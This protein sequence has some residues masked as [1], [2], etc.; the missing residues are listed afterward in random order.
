MIRDYNDRMFSIDQFFAAEHIEY[1]P[2]AGSHAYFE[3]ELG[4]ISAKAG[5]TRDAVLRLGLTFEDLVRGADFVLR[6]HTLSCDFGLGGRPVA[7]RGNT[8]GQKA[9]PRIS[10]HD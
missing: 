10:S 1:T 4:A 3:S 7:A 9:I 5:R 8:E 2:T 6:Q